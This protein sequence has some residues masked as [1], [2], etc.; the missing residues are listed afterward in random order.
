MTENSPKVSIFS[1][2]GSVVLAVRI[3]SLSR[4]NGEEPTIVIVPPR[5]AQNPIGIKRRDKGIEVRAE[6]LLTT[7]RNNAA[8]PTFCRKLEMKPTVPDTIGST[9]PSVVPPCF[10]ITAAT[11]FMIPVLSSPAPTI[12]T[13]MIEITA[14]EAKPSNSR[15]GVA[16][17]SRPGT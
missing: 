9:R 5:I 8:A 13:A 2:S 3:R 17:R 4:I 12:I 7:G 16:S 1:A 11:L 10:R 15:S 6:I 14:F